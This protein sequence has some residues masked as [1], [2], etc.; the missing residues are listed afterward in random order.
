[1]SDVER[2]LGEVADALPR[3]R[4]W[5][6]RARL[7]PR[8]ARAVRCGA[9]R[10]PSSRR[11]GSGR[12]RSG[13]AASDRRTPRGRCCVKVTG[14]VGV[15]LLDAAQ[16]VLLRHAVGVH[17]VAALAVAVPEVDRGALQGVAPLRG[18][19]HREGD[20]ER[21]AR[22]R[23][24]TPVPKLLV[25]SLRT[26][27]LSVSTLTP[28]E[29][30]AGNGPPVSSGISVPARRGRGAALGARGGSWWLGSR[31]P[32]STGAVRAAGGECGGQAGAAEQ[33]QRPAPAQQRSAGRGTGRG[34]ARAV[35]RGRGGRCPVHR[36]LS[37]RSAGRLV[38]R[39]WSKPGGPFWAVAVRTMGGR[40]GSWVS[41]RAMALV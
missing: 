11:R 12:P 15:G 24:R 9:C 38:G 33:A 39:C 18:V 23:R 37:V 22:R 32:M 28:F 21:H 36:C 29:P 8:A 19:E 2:R 10:W 7:A 6:R 41:V 35:R 4:R 13:C 1:M 40:R 25:M 34:R 17:R 20:G 30:S 27:P 3:S 16:V 5:R 26:M 31:W 14:A